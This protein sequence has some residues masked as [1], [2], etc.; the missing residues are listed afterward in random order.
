VLEEG[1]VPVR[2]STCNQ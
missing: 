2:G 1:Q